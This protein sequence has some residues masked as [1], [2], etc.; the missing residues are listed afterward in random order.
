MTTPN[1]AIGERNAGRGRVAGYRFLLLLAQRRWLYL[2]LLPL[3]LVLGLG[4]G[5]LNALVQ[6]LFGL[7]IGLF[8]GAT[9]MARLQW[10]QIRAVISVRMTL[11]WPVVIPLSLALLC[12]Y[13][14]GIGLFAMVGFFFYS[15]VDA[16]WLLRAVPKYLALA[17]SSAESGATADLLAAVG[18]ETQVGDTIDERARAGARNMR[19]IQMLRRP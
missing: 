7:A 9:D 1:G 13:A 19:L 3:L 12:I 2:S 17:R 15:L 8:I 11:F 4:L 10:A 16:L 5:L 18:R 6:G 14:L